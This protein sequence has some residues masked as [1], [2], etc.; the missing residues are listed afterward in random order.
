MDFK[1]VNCPFN[2]WIF[3]ITFN[4]LFLFFTGAL[5]K[6]ISPIQS[7]QH[8]QSRQHI[9]NSQYIQNSQH[10][11][12]SIYYQHILLLNILLFYILNMYLYWDCLPASLR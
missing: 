9:Q 4:K 12:N 10:I 11:Q 6:F 2:I 1:F 3:N 5:S 8:I 7:T